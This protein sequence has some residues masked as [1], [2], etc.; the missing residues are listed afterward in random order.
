[1]KEDNTFLLS[2]STG[3][4]I[5]WE[6]PSFEICQDKRRGSTYGKITYTVAKDPEHDWKAELGD[7][8]W[9]KHSNEVTVLRHMSAGF[10][11]IL[12]EV[13]YESYVNKCG[14]RGGQTPCRS[15]IGRT[16]IQTISGIT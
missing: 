1:M 5:D 8:E 10:T 7:G 11:M 9:Y 13:H 14:Q 12:L 6:H 15:G 4:I 16:A 2:K 3:W